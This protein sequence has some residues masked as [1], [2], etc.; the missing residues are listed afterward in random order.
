M[1]NTWISALGPDFSR[2]FFY[3]DADWDDAT[4][5]PVVSRYSDMRFYRFIKD[6]KFS[7]DREESFFMFM[8]LNGPH[9]SGDIND[10][11]SWGFHY[12]EESGTMRY[13]GGQTDIVHACF[14]MLNLYFTK[15]DE[16][17]VYDNSTIIIVGDHG[18]RWRIPEATA[19]MIKPKGSTGELTTDDITEL[20][21]KYF[22]S[23]ILDAAG[24]P[25]DESGISYFDII[26]GLLPAPPERFIYV[27]GLNST[28]PNG[29]IYGDYGVWEIVDDA[30]QVENWT[31]VPWDPLDF[32]P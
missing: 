25:R 15:M 1:K 3:L 24:L 32:F 7:A 28:T 11:G 5:I 10:P 18:L 9:S 26:N 4:F 29:R 23:S 14:E 2:S 31:F 27:K 12:D 17:G 22:P 13:G 30:N 6:A 20:S 21:T 19:L 8:H 16:I